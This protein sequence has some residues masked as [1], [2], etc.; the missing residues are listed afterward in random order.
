M[1]EKNVD[2]LI[3]VYNLCQEYYA[4]AEE[5]LCDMTTFIPPILE[6]RA[7]LEHVMRWIQ[8]NEDVEKN[9]AMGHLKRAFFDIVD[10]ICINVRND[11][12]NALRKVKKIK[13]EKCWDTYKE[14]KAKVY[15]MSEQLAKFRVHRMEGDT[16]QNSLKEPKEIVDE[17]LRIHKRFFTEVEPALKKS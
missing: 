15:H 1:A 17:F 7:A 3:Y 10:F 16:I 6:Y 4:L 9:K 13:I 12:N 8:N 11:I 5:C 14:E 2:D